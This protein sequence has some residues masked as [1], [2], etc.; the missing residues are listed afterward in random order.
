MKKVVVA[1]NIF[2]L[3]AEKFVEIAKDSIEKRGRFTVA[4]SGGSTP[5]GLYK[6]LKSER[7]RNQIDWNKVFFFFG[8]ER[9]VMPN[10]KQSNF[11]TARFFMLTSLKVETQSNVQRWL[12]E[13]KNPKLVAEY[14]ERDIK[15]FF[16][17]FPRFDLIFLG[18]GADG[19]TAS[20]FPETAALK[21][22]KRIAVENFVPKFGTYRLTFTFPTINN[23]RNIIFLISGQDKAKTLREVLHGD[24]KP[25]KLPSQM[26]KPIDGNLLILT[27]IEL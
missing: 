16:N 26:V 3:A 2:E 17:G 1:E 7:F 23:A 18:M 11:R 5:K 4:L 19:H 27:D 15:N 6:L 10:D 9:V 12:T 13:W 14:Q 22:D 25:E 21:E 8:D 24:F 20:L